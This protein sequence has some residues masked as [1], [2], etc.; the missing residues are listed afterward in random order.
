LKEFKP[1]YKRINNTSLLGESLD[2]LIDIFAKR[3][4]MKIKKID[5]DILQYIIKAKGMQN[6]IELSDYL[7]ALRDYVGKDTKGDAYSAFKKPLVAERPDLEILK[8]EE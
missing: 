5:R 6:A 1:Y 4:K 8:S 7:L 2:V 3:N